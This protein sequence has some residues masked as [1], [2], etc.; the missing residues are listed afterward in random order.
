MA[1]KDVLV[2]LNDRDLAALDK[3][4][5][6]GVAE[7]RAGAVAWC[8]RHFWQRETNWLD[9]LN[10]LFSVDNSLVAVPREEKKIVNRVALRVGKRLDLAA[11]EA[12]TSPL[13][14]LLVDASIILDVYRNGS[15]KTVAKR[16][17]AI[18]R[19]RDIAE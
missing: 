7:S 9:N 2:H 14:N 3:L 4:V 16:M 13:R 15:L 11:M 17:E 6:G 12:P 10:A 8:V 1:G 5:A 18:A 19:E